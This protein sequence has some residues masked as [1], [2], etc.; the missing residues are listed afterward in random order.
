MSSF[1]GVLRW[2]LHDCEFPLMLN[3]FPF[4]G[5][6]ASGRD[7]NVENKGVGEADRRDLLEK[8]EQN[9]VRHLQVRYITEI[10]I[11]SL[12]TPSKELKPLLKP[13][14]NVFMEM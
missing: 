3:S 7:R 2:V 4:L 6:S 1:P 11:F 14:L 5:L 10:F 12:T 9:A 13:D 8:A